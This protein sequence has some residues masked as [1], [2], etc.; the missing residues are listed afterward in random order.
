MYTE[1]T[2]F[3][4]EFYFSLIYFPKSNLTY[5]QC[6]LG[7]TYFL[8]YANLALFFFLSVFPV[9]SSFLLVYYYYYFLSTLEEG[10]KIG[11]LLQT[12]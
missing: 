5:V 4:I 3:W 7:L 1:P 6:V 11:Q 8:R 12:H 9:H 10:I 2:Y